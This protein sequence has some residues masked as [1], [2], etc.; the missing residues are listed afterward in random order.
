[1]GEY[2]MDAEQKANVKAS[3]KLAG[4]L[5]GFLAGLVLVWCLIS[6]FHLSDPEINGFTG[7]WH[8]ARME[9]TGKS[10][11]RYEE[12]P[13]KF[14]VKYPGNNEDWAALGV[15]HLHEACG[16]SGTAWLDG[17]LYTYFTGAFTSRYQRMV[18]QEA[19]ETEVRQVVFNEVVELCLG[20]YG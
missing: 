15:T 9:L 1:M 12:S 3:L 17:K 16:C 10:V 5:L 19:N 18:F 20:R 13:P 11:V 4:I 7:L 8:A 2:G 14:L 6:A